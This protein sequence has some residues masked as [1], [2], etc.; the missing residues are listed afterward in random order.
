MVELKKYVPETVMNKIK[1]S[2]NE[3]AI[4]EIKKKY[5]EQIDGRLFGPKFL[6]LWA[7]FYGIDESE[8]VR[9]LTNFL[10]LSATYYLIANF[11]TCGRNH[12]ILTCND[13]DSDIV[14]KKLEDLKTDYGRPIWDKPLGDIPIFWNIIKED[15]DHYYLTYL[16]SNPKKT[17]FDPVVQKFS[18]YFPTGI[19]NFRIHLD[20]SL[21]IE[22]FIKD[23]KRGKRLIALDKVKNLLGV[24][25]LHYLEISSGD[26]SNF[27]RQVNQV[28]HET[29][30]GDE[31]YT[32]LTR[33]DHDRDTRNEPVR[34]TIQNR[35]FRNENGI[36]YV[37]EIP[38]NIGIFRGNPG[39]IHFAKHL[40]SNEQIAIIHELLSILGWNV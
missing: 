22:E 16:H 17:Y 36:I 13:Y 3:K 28:T 25:S 31:A 34:Q 10:N 18:E 40:P 12:Y 11:F 1:E 26:I 27:D 37:N 30:D 35:P 20:H 14:I 8:P 19:I 33:A 4:N 7:R 2:D 39:K 24:G 9:S 38:Y 32:S 21:F 23:T 5:I 29:R 6:R 15:N